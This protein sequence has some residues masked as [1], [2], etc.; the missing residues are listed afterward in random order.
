MPVFF[1]LFI[2][3]VLWFRVKSKGVDK[4]RKSEME[5]FL[6]RE[7]EANFSRKQDI[8]YLDY[9]H[10]DK[11]DFPFNSTADGEEKEIQDRVLNLISSKLLNLSG[12]S[13]TDIKLQYGVANFEELAEYDQNYM[14]LQKE[15]NDWGA[16][17]Y[18]KEDMTHARQVLEYAIDRLNSDITET[19]TTLARIY[20][21]QD[22]PEKIRTLIDKAQM[23]DSVKREGII[24][25]LNDV[26]SEY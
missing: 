3:F 13:N 24:K 20:N 15:L 23:C 2:L 19:Y 12:M 26:I 22:M 11:E 5:E 10:I 21:A 6:E 14:L 16:F 1:I 17:L 8:T 9:I 4:Q 18:K 25:K 7:R